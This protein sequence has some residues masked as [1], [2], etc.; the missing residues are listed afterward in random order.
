MK[1]SF[2]Y[3]QLGLLPLGKDDGLVKVRSSSHEVLCL[4]LPSAVSW[5]GFHHKQIFSA[6]SC[7]TNMRSFVKSVPLSQGEQGNSEYVL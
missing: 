3:L 5:S 2:W 1:F 6:F 7:S 4:L